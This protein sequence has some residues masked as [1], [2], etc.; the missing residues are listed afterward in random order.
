MS[1]NIDSL[2]KNSL[3]PEYEPSKELNQ[4][5]LQKA[6]E[7][8]MS[9]LRKR[10]IAA[11]AAVI[12]L[13][14]LGSTTIYAAHKYLAPKEVASE[15]FENDKLAKAFEDENAILINEQTEDEGYI[16]TLLGITS[17]KNLNGYMDDSGQQLNESE[18]YVVMAIEN[19]D[20][21]PM[22]KVSDEDY[23]LNKFLI[24]PLISDQDPWIVNIYSLNGFATEMTK[25]GI[26][27]RIISCSDLNIFADRGVYLAVCSELSNLSKGYVVDKENHAITQN[28][29]FDGLNV[30]FKLP[31]DVTKA[32]R[33][34]SEQILRQILNPEADSDTDIQVISDLISESGEYAT[35]SSQE[36]NSEDFRGTYPTPEDLKEWQEWLDAGMPGNDV[37]RRCVV[38]S[39]TE[40][41]VSA[42]Q[43]GIYELIDENGFDYI[44]KEFVDTS[45]N[46]NVIGY[47]YG[48]TIDSLQIKM[49]KYNE[50]DTITYAIY[51]PKEK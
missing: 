25:D 31:L 3:E 16:F 24:T 30:L 44:E 15:V 17:G 12:T 37:N 14:L 5:I 50:D 22:P 33:N 27:Y 8:K 40:Q 10:P 21:T 29:S 42:G 23:D 47:S 18:I 20:G 32:D 36:Y 51:T 28:E 2:L 38:V 7:N 6:K 26:T 19:S 41:T 35:E 43:N 11:A 48:D 4:T 13:T 34:K 46:W 9:K 49:Y 1:I 39:G 45:G